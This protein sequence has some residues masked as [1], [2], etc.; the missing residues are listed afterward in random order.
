MS[1][2]Y[3]DE[4]RS[5][6]GLYLFLAF[7][8]VSLIVI[9]LMATKCSPDK[10]KTVTKDP[11]AEEPVE[12]E[13]PSGDPF[14]AMPEPEPT[15]EVP[16]PLT[17]AEVLTAAGIGAAELDPASLLQKIGASL[18]AGE[19]DKAAAL[20]GKNALSESH[21]TGLQALADANKLRIHPI[22]PIS[23]IGELEANR[24]AR[25]ALNLDD[26]F[27]SRIYFDLNRKAD[28]KWAVEK[29]TLPPVVEEGKV[30]PRAIFVDA[31]GI[32]DSFLNAAL[33]QEFDDAKS[34]VDPE[35]VS[36]AKIAGLCIIFEEAKYQLRNQK[37]LRAMFSSETTAGFKANVEDETGER[38]AEFGLTVQ[39]ADATQPW[40]VTE[41]NLDQLLTDYA[42]RIA[43]GDVHFTPLVKNPAGGDTLILYFGFDENGLTPR[44]ER[45]LDIVASLLKT[46]PSKK[47]TLS[48]HTD[49]LG[50]DD[51][52]KGLSKN[53]AIAVKEYLLSVG[54]PLTQMI[55]QAEGEA[56]P[57]LPNVLEDGED[58]PS[59]RRAN[60]RTEIYL[61]F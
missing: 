26:P 56:K 49:A 18:H 51:Y 12:A 22:R 25:W 46:D 13:Q 24:R 61:D 29:V 33:K 47:L 3:S 21:L 36:D 43:G 1:S 15:P 39:R 35:K 17:P 8:A 14:E 10:E 6:F 30:P 40:R 52:N 41:V 38:A 37:P 59:G 45:Q 2:Y 7:I 16:T 32:T 60:R 50:S 54:V 27:S 48:G 42:T 19:L 4:P 57:R 53:R 11:S 5:N 31:L 55:A 23:E 58:N 9:G 20:I 28:G 44:T 34:F